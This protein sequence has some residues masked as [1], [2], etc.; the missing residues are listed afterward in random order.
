MSY[1]ILTL[2]KVYLVEV[3]IYSSW[4]ISSILGVYISFLF[5]LLHLLVWLIESYT[6]RKDVHVFGELRYCRSF[7]VVCWHILWFYSR[8]RCFY[9]YCY[10]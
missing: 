1:N 6:S 9:E 4:S 2:R 3:E 5:I 8:L 10:L 7:E